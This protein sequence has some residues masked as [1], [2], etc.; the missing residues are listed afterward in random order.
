M[1]ALFAKDDLTC[2]FSRR[3]Y[4]A[5]T[6]NTGFATHASGST[7]SF[8]VAPDQAQLGRKHTHRDPLA[9]LV[10]GCGPVTGLLG[11]DGAFNI[12]LLV[13]I[14]VVEMA[15]PDGEQM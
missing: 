9:N 14:E 2:D 11:K 1:P 12:C 8:R 5:R 6:E 7:H 13:E 4:N 15:E 10:R 3:P